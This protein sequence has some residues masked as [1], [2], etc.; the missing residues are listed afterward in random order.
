MPSTRFVL[1][2][3]VSA[4]IASLPSTNGLALRGTPSTLSVRQSSATQFEDCTLSSSLIGP[5]GQMLMSVT[6]KHRGQTLATGSTTFPENFTP[7]LCWPTDVGQGPLYV[8]GT[9]MEFGMEATMCV[10]SGFTFKYA[11]WTGSSGWSEGG[12][13]GEFQEDNLTND[14]TFPCWIWD[15]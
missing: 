10:N 4:I 3:L 1:P 13:N 7:G 11:A 9:G 5:E 14:I 6:I 2:L 8:T 12:P 15:H